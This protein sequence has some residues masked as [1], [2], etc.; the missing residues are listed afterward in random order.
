MAAIPDIRVDRRALQIQIL[1]I[2]KRLF[3]NHD[4]YHAHVR[5]KDNIASR[6]A[7]LLLEACCWN[8]IHQVLSR[9]MRSCR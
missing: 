2:A 5:R 6:V 4:L 9:P 3:N 7:P 1:E 8:Q